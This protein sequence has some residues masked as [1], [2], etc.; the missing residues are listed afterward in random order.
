MLGALKMHRLR[1]LLIANPGA[2]LCNSYLI[3]I[4]TPL[5]CVF[6]FGEIA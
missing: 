5:G 2:A 6:L 3:L 4:V 1:G